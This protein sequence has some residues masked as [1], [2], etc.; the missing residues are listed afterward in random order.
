MASCGRYAWKSD[1]VIPGGDAGS[2]RDGAGAANVGRA[3]LRFRR[4]VARSRA[5]VRPSRLKSV[6]A[7]TG[8]SVFSAR[9]TADRSKAL[10]RHP[11]GTPPGSRDAA[12][13]GRR[14]HVRLRC[15]IEKR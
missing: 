6:A 8:A 9:L 5:L 13:G 11:G 14:R 10:T 4:T 2:S 15:R 3:P 12:L 1:C 7:V